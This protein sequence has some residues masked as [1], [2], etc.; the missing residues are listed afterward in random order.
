MAL[1]INPKTSCEVELIKRTSWM[2]LMVMDSGQFLKWD[3][4]IG[5]AFQSDTVKCVPLTAQFMKLSGKEDI[6]TN[7]IPSPKFYVC[8]QPIQPLLIN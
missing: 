2:R 3:I 1:R 7:G 6:A 5:F 8:L 4:F